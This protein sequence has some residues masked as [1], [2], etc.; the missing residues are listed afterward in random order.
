MVDASS[1]QSTTIMARTRVR[2]TQGAPGKARTKKMAAFTAI[3]AAAAVTALVAGNQTRHPLMTGSFTGA[4][5]LDELLAGMCSF[6][7]GMSILL[8]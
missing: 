1:V 6:S 5:W 2:K 4:M 8:I 7:D 3:T